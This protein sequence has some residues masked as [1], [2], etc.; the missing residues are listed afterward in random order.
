MPG[1]LSRNLSETPSLYSVGV[2]QWDQPHSSGASG[3]SRAAARQNDWF[4]R[5]CWMKDIDCVWCVEV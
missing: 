4:Q 2:S 3:A 5:R 1:K